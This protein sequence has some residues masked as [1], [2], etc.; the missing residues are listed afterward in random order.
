MKMLPVLAMAVLAGASVSVVAQQPDQTPQ[1]AQTAPAAST[2]NPATQSAPQSNPGST[3][4]DATS[5]A[6][7]AVDMRPVSGELQGKLDSQSA[8]AGDKVVVKTNEPVKTADG[9][10]IPKGSKLV[11]RVAKVQSHSQG[12]QNSAVGIEFDH[13]ELKGGQ[14]VQIASVIK[15][16]APAAGNSAPGGTDSMPSPMAGSNPSSGGM[17]G[18]SGG[19]ASANTG[20]TAPMPQPGAAPATQAPGAASAGTV[21]GRTGKDPIVTTSIP[22]V[23]LAST[24]P[25]EATTMS[26]VLFAAKSEVHLEGGTQVGMEVAVAGAK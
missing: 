23:F 14:S 6:A 22:G 18:H 19:G 21:V 2:Q 5:A 26:G 4:T 25:S 13:A 16:L 1:P 10:V 15:T 11:G 7:P 17:A 9:T 8:K 12:S 24:T 3:A 20:S